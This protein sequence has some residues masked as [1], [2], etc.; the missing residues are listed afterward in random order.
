MKNEEK[1]DDSADSGGEQQQ[2]NG[3]T[4]ARNPACDLCREKKV[5]CGREK[6]HCK[7]CRQ[8]KAKCTYSER[9]KR[10]NESSRIAH[11]FEEV[12]D[13]LDRLE[14]TMSRIAV[15][16]E[17]SN[18]TTQH[19]QQQ[20]QIQQ[21]QQQQQQAA[22]Q[23]QQYQQSQQPQSQSSPYSPPNAFPTPSTYPSLHSPTQQKDSLGPGTPTRSSNGGGGFGA[24]VQGAPRLSTSHTGRV[25]RGG[26][27]PPV[28]KTLVKDTKGNLH[29]LGASSILSIS[30]EA[31]SLAE[32]KL[33]AA[34]ASSGGGE[35]SNKGEGVDHAM[36]ALKSLHGLDNNIASLLPYD[37]FMELKMGG[38]DYIAPS[39]QEA[40]RLID[41]FFER[42]N[43]YFPL[44]RRDTFMKNVNKMYENPSAMNDRGWLVCFNNVLLF[45][46]YGSTMNGQKKEEIQT[47]LVEKYFFNSWAA[48]D[49]VSILL[50]PSLIN[51][52]ALLTLAIVAQEISKPGLCWI[53]LSQACRLAQAIGLHRQSHPSQISSNEEAQERKLVFWTLYVMDKALSLTFGRS[54]CLPDFDIDVDLPENNSPLDEHFASWV[55]LAK[56]QSQIYM[57]LYS[58]S[59]CRASDEERQRAAA[60]L[61]LDLR[62]WWAQ[63]GAGLEQLPA[64]G[65]FEQRYIELEIKFSF[66]NSMIM[67][68][69][70]NRAGGELSEAICLDS[71]RMSVQ[72]IKQTLATDNE[73]ADGSVLLWLF[74]YFPFTPFFILFSNVVRNPEARQARDDFELMQVVVSYLDRMKAANEN[75]SK[76]LKIAAAFTQIA[77]AFL[78]KYVEI[79]ETKLKRGSKRKRETE[80]ESK[81]GEAEGEGARPPPAVRTQGTGEE[82]LA[83]SPGAPAEMADSSLPSLPPP[84][85]TIDV[86]VSTLFPHAFNFLRW[87]H[88]ASKE[89][90]PPPPP[91][92]TP[93]VDSNMEHDQIP[94][95]FVPPPLDGGFDFD[96]EALMAEPV[97]FQ[98]QMQQAH[99]QGPLDFDWFQW[100]QYTQGLADSPGPGLS[101]AMAGGAAGVRQPPQ[102]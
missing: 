12:H 4:S 66:H 84:A 49:D 16:L 40:N 6:P 99:R 51:V 82:T 37:G 47:A 69:R 91:Q 75:A 7:N 18:M 19:N 21:Q 62:N 39:R 38:R 34:A 89:N 95:S 29:Y 43:R 41:A 5:K 71:A 23:Q 33:A 81:K 57:R 70:V 78:K 65:L 31:G 61:E 73:L 22:A 79:P 14:S 36:G 68:H 28:Q 56:I 64:I 2:N 101:A 3:G 17:L 45:S 42:I 67:I 59:A 100:D 44:F 10:E 90:P 24:P 85:P 1:K 86:D 76:L 27:P 63:N 52:Q 83:A 58:A 72:L 74:Q 98:S 13:R 92:H 25:S 15:A 80:K 55:W 30:T 35:A 94:G 48:F 96:I 46:L 97:D 93:L 11:K 20:Y 50:T 87:P 53:L 102:Q 54:T 88:T 60:E 9:Q 8:W 77:A 32:A 26:S